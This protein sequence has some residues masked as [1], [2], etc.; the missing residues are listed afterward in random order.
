L[1]AGRAERGLSLD[2]GVLEPGRIADIV[3][4]AGDPIA[5]IG[6]TAEVDFV[7]RSGHLHR[8]PDDAR[9][10]RCA[11]QSDVRSALTMARGPQVP[12]TTQPHSIRCGVSG[13]SNTTDPNMR[14]YR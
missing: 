9:L 10:H 11:D 6:R 1:H 14:V 12:L 4:M 2:I 5:N 7:M 3:A 13:P 8:K